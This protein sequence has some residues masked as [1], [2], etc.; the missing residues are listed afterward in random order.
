MPSL[1]TPKLLKKFGA[2]FADAGYECYLVGGATRNMI[3]GLPTGDYDIATNATPEEVQSLF[4]RVIPT[5]VDHGTVTVLFRGFQIEVTTYRIDG[6]YSDQRH[7]DDVTFV[8]SI[9]EDLKRRDFTMNAIALDCV[10]GTVF[11]PLDGQSDIASKTIRAIGNPEKRFSEDAL[12]TLRAFRFA[13]QLGFTIEPAT[14]SAIGAHAP[15]LSHVSAE[16]IRDELLKLLVSDSPSIG[17]SAMATSGILRVILPELDECRGVDQKGM[18]VY[19]VFDH[20]LAACDAVPATDMVV[21]T[22]A[23]FHD[24]GKPR[25]KRIDESGTITFH[26]HEAIS[27][28]LAR[29]ILRR[30]RCSREFEKDVLH[31]VDN[32]MF[33]YESNWTDGAVRRFVHRV[34]PEYIT[35][36]FSLRLA[37]SEAISGKKPIHFPESLAELGKRVDQIITAEDALTIG[38]LSVD[39]NDLSDFAGIPKNHQMGVVMRYLLE[40]VLDD[41]ALNTP[42]TLLTL[43]RNFGSSEKSVGKSSSH[44]LPGQSGNLAKDQKLNLNR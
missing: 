33:H 5:G 21:R 3:L 30:L 41:P 42:Q 44:S 24:I 31:L 39:G 12:R 23:L 35:N 11:D 32:H 28:E 20:S 26:R 16:R 9:D 18:H 1:N 38:D 40:S 22:A 19:D 14:I 25:A 4:R 37:D 36:L 34:G 8:G 15:E 7:P 43:A 10:H 2:I 6:K 17:F 29:N 27:V 13:A